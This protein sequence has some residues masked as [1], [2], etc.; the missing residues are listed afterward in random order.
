MQVHCE[1]MQQDGFFFFHP[2]FLSFS[3]LAIPKSP[4]GHFRQQLTLRWPFIIIQS[5][6]KISLLSGADHCVPIT[7]EYFPTCVS[8]YSPPLSFVFLHDI[9]QQLFTI[10][11][12]KSGCSEQCCII[13]KLCHLT[14]AAFPGC[15]WI[16]WRTCL[17]SFS[18]RKES[19]CKLWFLLLISYSGNAWLHCKWRCSHCFD[20]VLS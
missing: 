19:N 3:F 16:E 6:S 2:V 9:L 13:S 20:P 17:K 12:S 18:I 10:S 4:S 5:D 1:F 11:F 8:C 15:L 7:S 14:C